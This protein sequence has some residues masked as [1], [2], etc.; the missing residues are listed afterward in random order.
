LGAG[1]LVAGL[2]LFA[3]ATRKPKTDAKPDVT[4]T[5]TITKGIASKK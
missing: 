5:K 2:A 1:A 4:K 3:Y